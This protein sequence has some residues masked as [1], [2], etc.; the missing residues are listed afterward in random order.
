ML[1]SIKRGI[2]AASIIAL[3][4]LSHSAFAKDAPRV[5]V[6]IAPLHSLVSGIMIGIGVPS[7]LLQGNASPHD[8]TLKPSQMEELARAQIIIAT[9]ADAERYLQ[10]IVDSL[11]SNDSDG[12]ELIE[13]L[14]FEEILKLPS[15]IS[16]EGEGVGMDMHFWMNPDNA[17]IVT[18]HIVE[19][20]SAKDPPH[21]KQY[22][23]NGDAVIAELQR[24]NHT[25][26]A[27]L[28]IGIKQAAYA[29]YHPA[30]QYFEKR[31]GITG[32]HAITKTPEIGASILEVA[33]LEQAIQARAIQ[34]LF[35]EPQFPNKLIQQL[36]EQYHLPVNAADAMGAG[37]APGKL[38][39]SKLLLKVAETIKPCLKVGAASHE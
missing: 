32:S 25:I 2:A 26:E 4:G 24:L 16:H 17:I 28:G 34:C 27:M 15:T 35:E 30:W 12:Q 33:H 6:T 7:L 20:L 22:H 14:K 23:K 1:S 36:S 5:V 39:Y 18:H 13:T 3:C 11:Q 29:T 19:T 8:Y 9:S 31:Y 10:P 21:K 37:I 38:M